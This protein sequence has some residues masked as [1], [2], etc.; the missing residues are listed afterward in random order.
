MRTQAKPVFISL[1]D[2][3]TYS[4]SRSQTDFYNL[5]E[6]VTSTWAVQPFNEWTGSVFD[7]F[8]NSYCWSIQH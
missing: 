3:A 6:F 8:P 4:L 2:N 7:I 1:I 5:Y